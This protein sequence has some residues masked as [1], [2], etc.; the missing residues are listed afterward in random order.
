MVN[1]GPK[2]ENGNSPDEQLYNMLLDPSETTNVAASNPAIVNS[3]RLL[4][5]RACR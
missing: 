5:N 4:H 1:W 2:I 3:L